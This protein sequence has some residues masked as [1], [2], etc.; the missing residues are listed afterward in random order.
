MGIANCE[1]EYRNRTDPADPAFLAECLRDFQA[2]RS[3]LDDLEG[4]LEAYRL[5]TLPEVPHDNH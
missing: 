2:M 1:T 5:L 3:M 4:G